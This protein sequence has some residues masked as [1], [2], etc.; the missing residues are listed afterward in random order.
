MVFLL[1]LFLALFFGIVLAGQGMFG[2]HL[3]HME[4]SGESANQA[5]DM[6][7]GN[8]DG[9]NSFLPL[10][11]TAGLTYYI[12]FF[13]FLTLLFLNFIMAII[14]DAY[15]EVKTEYQEQ[16]ELAR[17]PMENLVG[18]ATMIWCQ[19]VPKMRAKKQRVDRLHHALEQ[20]RRKARR[21]PRSSSGDSAEERLDPQL[22]FD[23]FRKLLAPSEPSDE[24]LDSLVFRLRLAL[25]SPAP[26]RDAPD[27]SSR[28]SA[29]MAANR[30][31]QKGSNVSG[32]EVEA[33]E[34]PVEMRV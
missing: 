18:D 6:M 30:L 28:A 23:E 4:T 10:S 3:P 16:G 9:L 33:E 14:F 1:P 11:V 13:F 21:S 7:T 22:T 25:V 12:S 29:V 15:A 5:L 27:S 32:S 17:S 26:E 20:R 2:E 8:G 31:W 34:K 24:E 19:C